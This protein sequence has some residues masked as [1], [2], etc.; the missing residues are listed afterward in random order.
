MVTCVCPVANGLSHLGCCSTNGLSD[1][2]QLCS[3]SSSSWASF[4]FLPFQFLQESPGSLEKQ[5]AGIRSEGALMLESLPGMERC[6]CALKNQF[7]LKLS[8]K[9]FA[10]GF[11]YWS[12]GVC[13][14]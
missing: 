12:P 14:V 11:F 7:F 5:V 6:S 13:F 4:T 10:S 1:T 3:Q 9:R 2:W 8:G